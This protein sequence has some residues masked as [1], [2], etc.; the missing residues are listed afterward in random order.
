M[1]TKPHAV[2]H[3]APVHTLH[4]PDG[5]PATDDYWYEPDFSGDQ[6]LCR[7]DAGWAVLTSFI[8]NAT[9]L[10]RKSPFREDIQQLFVRYAQALDRSDE[11]TAFVNL[12]GVLESVTQ[13][14]RANYDKTIARATWIYEDREQA[15]EELGYLRMQRNR[16][17]HAS[18]STQDGG[19]SVH[20]LKAI[21]DSHLRHL[22]VNTFKVT[23]IQEYASLLDL[24]A[25]TATL[26]HKRD[27][28][29]KALRFHAVL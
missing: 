13:T 21:V 10:L 5:S 2:V 1:Q 29:N 4:N 11:D 15:A 23:S 24:P 6:P 14:G 27:E 19:S 8:R 26:R 17:V 12:W 18:A 7:P 20:Q 16:I 22:L 28:L 3:A 25:S 9:R